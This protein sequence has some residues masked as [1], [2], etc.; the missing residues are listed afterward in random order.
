MTRGILGRF[1]AYVNRISKNIEGFLTFYQ[2]RILIPQ[3]ARY[4]H[5]GTFFGKPGGGRADSGDMPRCWK[6]TS[7]TISPYVPDHQPP[8]EGPG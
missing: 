2:V 8:D 3:L 4:G 6:R 5:C 1:W 7:A